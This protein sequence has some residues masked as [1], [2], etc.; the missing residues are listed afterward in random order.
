MKLTSQQEDKV[1]EKVRAIGSGFPV[2][3]KVMTV[4]DVLRPTQL[5]FCMEFTSA[6]RLPLEQ[7]PLLLGLEGSEMQWYTALTF[8]T[9]RK[10]RWISSLWRNF[11]SVSGM[12]AGDICLFELVDRSSERLRMTVHLIR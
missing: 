4:H 8:S 12:K 6:C 10:V 5:R 11:V 9:Y 3:V 7:M 2:F 1:K